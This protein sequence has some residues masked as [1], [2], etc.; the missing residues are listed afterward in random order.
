MLRER[1]SRAVE[2]NPPLKK[3]EGELLSLIQSIDGDAVLTIILTGSVAE[4]RYV[5]GLSDIDIIVIKKEGRPSHI[6][7]AVGDIDV[8]ITF[9]G[10]EEAL[11]AVKTGNTFI[12]QALEKGIYLKG[13]E[14]GRALLD[15]YR[16]S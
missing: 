2:K 4:G 12:I 13:G 14:T 5:H 1:L 7:T 16:G 11:E 8:E 3:L 10:L 6:L 9:L 15:Y